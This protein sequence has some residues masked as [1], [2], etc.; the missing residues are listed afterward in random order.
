[1]SVRTRL[2]LHILQPVLDFVFFG[3]SIAF[4]WT[5]TVDILDNTFGKFIAMFGVL[6]SK[7]HIPF[8]APKAR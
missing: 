3:F 4:D 1:M 8:C 6:G 7:V 5:A 2:V